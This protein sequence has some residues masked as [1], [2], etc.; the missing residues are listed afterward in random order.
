MAATGENPWPLPGSPVA[1]YGED[2]TAADSAAACGAVPD[3]WHVAGFRRVSQSGLRRRNGCR[4][5]VLY[6]R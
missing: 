2:L 6:Q 4:R 1:A 5:A 3:Q